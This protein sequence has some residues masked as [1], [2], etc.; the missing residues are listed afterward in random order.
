MPDIQT[1]LE[2]VNRI[3]EGYELG[4]LGTGQE[5]ASAK[6]IAS[7]APPSRWPGV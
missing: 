3:A 6:F 1:I 5:D 4:N 7:P 2:R